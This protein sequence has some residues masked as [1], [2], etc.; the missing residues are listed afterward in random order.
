MKKRTKKYIFI[1]FIFCCLSFLTA[2]FF[3]G[4][5]AAGAKDIIFWHLRVP[6]ALLGF[7]VGAG[8]SI[9]GA[10]LQCILRNPLADP[11]IIGASAG[12]ALGSILFSYAGFVYSG[13]L[14]AFLF[15]ILA[16]IIVFNMAERAKNT[17]PHTIILSGV[18]VSS[19]FSALTLL[20]MT[21]KKENAYEI[22][23]FLTG[24]L[25]GA[26]T[27]EILIAGIIVIFGLTFIFGHGRSLNILSLSDD[28]AKSLGVDAEKMRK[29]MYVC[30]GLIIACCVS[31]AGIIGFVGLIVPHIVRITL[32]ADHRKLI[33]GSF[34]FGGG[35][36][37]LCDSMARVLI[38]PVEL[39]VGVITAF[40]GAPFFLVLL[41]RRN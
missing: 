16:I 12:A 20:A 3:G 41:L 13:T 1:Y 37:V 8:L 2:L 35:F 26:D 23:F 31:V 32:G 29:L 34:L 28:E 5:L 36:L 22:L 27:A 4:A 25:Q 14:G 38:A 17:T 39:P 30:S 33:V 15:G 24:S 21:L 7:F 11:Y 40:T 19:F 18:I 10:V 9:A 6:R